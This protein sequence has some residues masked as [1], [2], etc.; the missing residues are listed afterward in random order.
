MYNGF[1]TINGLGNNYSLDYKHRFR[2]IIAKE[3]EKDEWIH[4]Y[5]DRA[6]SRCFLYCHELGKQCLCTKHHP[7]RRVEHL[8]IDTVALR[9]IGAEYILSA[10]DIVNYKSLGLKLER[11]FERDD[12]PWQIYL[13]SIEQGRTPHD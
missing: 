5:F 12:S 1:W 6:G 11:V 13:Y 7:I 9:Q 10:V 4:N 2:K 8:E 3:L